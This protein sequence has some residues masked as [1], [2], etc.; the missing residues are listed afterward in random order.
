MS[1][2]PMSVIVLIFCRTLS[3]DTAGK[4]SDCRWRLIAVVISVLFWVFFGV[5]KKM[6]NN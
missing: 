6:K 1:S 2:K 5:R 3:Y 4:D